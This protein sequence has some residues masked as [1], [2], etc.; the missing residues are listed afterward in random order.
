MIKK[1]R[2][3]EWI[4]VIFHIEAMAVKKDVVE[5]AL[6]QLIENMGHSEDVMI[7]ETNFG[8]ILEVKNPPK[9]VEKAFSQIVEV[10][11]MVKNV[12]GLISLA[13][14]Y[15]PSSVEI[16]GPDRKS[17]GMEEMQGLANSVAGLVHQFA[18]AGIGGLVIT[19]NKQKEC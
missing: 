9:N 6:K 1:R 18:Q 16:L 13:T 4:D 10:R 17:I 2:K 19:P 5:S 14:L 8:K 12:I 3:E 11:F 15:G 7:Y